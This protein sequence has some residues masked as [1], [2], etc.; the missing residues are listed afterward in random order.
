MKNEKA[1]T[2]REQARGKLLAAALVA[3]LAWSN[4]VAAEPAAQPTPSTAPTPASK[5]EARDRFDRGL[6]LFE[7]GETAGALAEFKRANEL[8][9]NPL[10]LYNMGLVYAAMNRP[11]DAVQALEGFLS[12]STAAQKSQRKHAEEVRDEQA[13]RIARLLVKT[14]VPATVDIDGVEVARTPLAQPI[15]V[16][17]GTHV[18]GAQAP[19]Y[20][21]TRK[22]VTLAGQ[23][24]E[25]LTLTLLPAASRMAQLSI[26]SSPPGA[27]VMVN[28]QRQGMT[29]LPASLA[30]EPGNVRIELFRP[31]Y[32]RA[33]RT[34]MLGDGARSELAFALE[35]DPSAPPAHR[36]GLRLS[37]SEAGAEVAIDGRP[38]GIGGATIGLPVGPHTLRVTHAG[39]EPFEQDITISPAREEHLAISLTPTAETRERYEARVRTRRWTGY[40]VLSTGAALAIV[41]GVYGLT[42]QS[43]VTDSRRQLDTVLAAEANPKNPCYALGLDYGLRHCGETQS[44]ARDQVDQ[45]VLRRNL[46]FIGAGVGLVTVGVGTYLLLSNDDP[47]RYRKDTGPVIT[48]GTAWTNGHATGIALSGTY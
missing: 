36:G 5:A 14:E 41:G 8:V 47:H 17:S 1:R 33:E 23:V 35:D 31:G 34:V 16:A 2:E 18:V 27:E 39:F 43:D 6:R 29:P 12:Q 15:P 42:K 21:P 25:T 7:K 37:A 10:V 30:V 20:L 11:V 28:G 38:R 13:T 32:R 44:S 46:G 9:P 3:C 40:A 26:T 22:E 45:A 19:G 24:T 4:P 48:A